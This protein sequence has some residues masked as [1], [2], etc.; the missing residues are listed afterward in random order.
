MSSFTAESAISEVKSAFES[1]DF[2]KMF[3]LIE[4]R[5]GSEWWAQIVAKM[6]C[7][8]TN[9][10]SQEAVEWTEMIQEFLSFQFQLGEF[11]PCEELGVLEVKEEVVE[12]LSLTKGN[13]TC[14][15]EYGLDNRCFGRA[16]EAR[17]SIDELLHEKYGK[18]SMW[19][20]GNLAMYIGMCNATPKDLC[21][22]EMGDE[23]REFPINIRVPKNVLSYVQHVNRYPLN[24]ILFELL[25]KAE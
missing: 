18:V 19:S 20:L 11:L 24:N 6:P 17:R 3:H 9:T 2:E 5:F 22:F 12:F 21:S 8:H 13:I 10:V 25:T 15:G 23:G 16:C 4:S 7:D 1:K 14:L